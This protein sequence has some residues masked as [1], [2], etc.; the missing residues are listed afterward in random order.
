MRSYETMEDAILL[1][2]DILSTSLDANRGCALIA[3]ISRKLG[4]PE[5]LEMFTALAHDQSG[6]ESFGIDAKSSIDDIVFACRELLLTSI[7]YCKPKHD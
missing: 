6:H 3:A 4:H 7:S 2:E 5:S 1:A